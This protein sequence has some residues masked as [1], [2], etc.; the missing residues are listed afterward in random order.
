MNATVP[1]VICIWVAVAVSW[2]AHASE[3]PSDSN[4]TKP[5]QLCLSAFPS[6]QRLQTFPL[7]VGQLFSL[8][9]VHSVSLTPVRDIYQIEKDQIIQIAEI[10]SAHGAGLPSQLNEVDATEWQHQDGQFMLHMR[11]SIPTLIVRVQAD[12]Q[13]RLIIGQQSYLLAEWHEGAV[14]LQPCQAY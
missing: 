2:F 11:R 4:Q 14:Q 3:N 6:N 1:Y 13:N 7:K 8:Q 12:Y 9:F 5:Y 10:F